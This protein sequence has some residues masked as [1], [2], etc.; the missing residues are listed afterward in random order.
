VKFGING[1][2]GRR[3]ALVRNMARGEK[4]FCCPELSF[5][6]S[7]EQRILVEWPPLKHA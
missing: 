5:S 2:F 7:L 3:V 1:P 6:S 4:I